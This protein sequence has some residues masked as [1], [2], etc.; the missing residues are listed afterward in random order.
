[1]IGSH[2][3]C[4][5]NFYHIL[6]HIYYLL[7]WEEKAFNTKF[8]YDKSWYKYNALLNIT[9]ML[10]DSHGPLSK[11]GKWPLG[12]DGLEV[13]RGIGNCKITA[14]SPCGYCPWHGGLYRSY[15]M[16]RLDPLMVHSHLM[17]NQYVKWKSRWHPRWHPMLNGQQLIIK[18]ML[19]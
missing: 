2:A 11:H 14:F 16:Q 12:V 15:Q 19:V 1:M 13:E 3:T 17:L 6:F 18:W 10:L 5:F 9:L 7:V 4:T 8:E